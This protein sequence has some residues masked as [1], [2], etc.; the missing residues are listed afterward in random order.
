MADAD[1]PHYRTTRR[2]AITFIAFSLAACGGPT[3]A[4]T[5]PEGAKADD[6]TLTRCQA[7]TD[8]GPR[9]ADCGTLIVRQAALHHRAP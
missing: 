4:R 5:V 6:L 7:R 9:V 2:F 3:T 8:S 1:M